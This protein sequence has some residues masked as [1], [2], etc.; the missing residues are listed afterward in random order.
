MNSK[1][2]QVVDSDGYVERTTRTAGFSLYWR[3]RR[4]GYIFWLP[5]GGAILVGAWVLIPQYEAEYQQEQLAKAFFAQ[6]QHVFEDTSQVPKIPEEALR[7]AEG[8]RSLTNNALSSWSPT[9]A[10][11]IRDGYW[12]ALIDFKSPKPFHREKKIGVAVNEG[13]F[14]VEKP[15]RDG[16]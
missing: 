7:T 14:E 3:L 6:C 10:G 1:N 2:G 4:L 8:Q 11:V 12:Y 16:G 13:A 15:N 5:I 9:V